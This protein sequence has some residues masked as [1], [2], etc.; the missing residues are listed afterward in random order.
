MDKEESSQP[1][2]SLDEKSQMQV[3]DDQE[4]QTL[5]AGSAAANNEPATPTEDS[6]PVAKVGTNESDYEYITGLKLALVIIAV[7]IACF[8]MLL[9]N[10][11]VATVSGLL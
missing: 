8:L 11:I 6:P 9:D 10:S 4:K 2:A 1:R 3:S 7:T 5:S